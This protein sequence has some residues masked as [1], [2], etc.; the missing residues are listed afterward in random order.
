MPMLHHFF[1]NY[2]IAFHYPNDLFICNTNL[3]HLLQ[4]YFNI[5]QLAVPDRIIFSTF[6]VLIIEVLIF[7][8][9]SLE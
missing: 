4:P 1:S 5:L 6:I 2:G 8:V 9:H 3:T 7:K